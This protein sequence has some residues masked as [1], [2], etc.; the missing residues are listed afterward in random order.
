MI[1]NII[2]I[3]KSNGIICAY[4]LS[5]RREA[6]LDSYMV[7]ACYITDA[8]RQDGNGYLYRLSC[9][10]HNTAAVAWSIIQAA[11]VECDLSCRYI[12][13]RTSNVEIRFGGRKPKQPKQPKQK[14]KE[15]EK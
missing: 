11:G 13:G 4:G 1:G 5:S 15:A 8:A 7:P 6:W 3:L 14:G 2:E 9:N 10:F 12:D